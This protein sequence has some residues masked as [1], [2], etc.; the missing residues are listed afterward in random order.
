MP[1]FNECAT[2]FAWTA[3]ALQMT[4][5]ERERERERGRE[6]ER[7]RERRRREKRNQISCSKDKVTACFV[8][9]SSRSRYPVTIGPKQK[10]KNKIKESAAQNANAKLKTHLLI[11]K[12]KKSVCEILWHFTNEKEERKKIKTFFSWNFQKRLLP[13]WH[14]NCFNE[15]LEIRNFYSDFAVT[16]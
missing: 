3:R 4:T 5:R 12:R 10:S 8:F 7:K 13:S 6:R 15:N 9:G 11:W 2:V 1:A 16:N 14:S